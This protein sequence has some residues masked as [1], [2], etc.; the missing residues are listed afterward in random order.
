MLLN[1]DNISETVNPRFKGGEGD[2]ISRMYNDGFNKIMLGRLPV[3]ANIGY[4]KHEEN[5]EIIYILSGEGRCLYDDGEELL[6][7][8]DC[9]YCPLGH[10]HSL[11]NNSGTE[12]L[13]FFAVVP[14]HKK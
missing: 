1:F 14:E 7:P 6:K 5:S 13:V 2:F 4:H 8:G 10:S 3:G 11:I 9:H 12:E